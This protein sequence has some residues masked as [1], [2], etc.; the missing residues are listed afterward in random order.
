MW[1]LSYALCD[2]VKDGNTSS[3]HQSSSPFS[4]DK[5]P[6]QDTVQAAELSSRTKPCKGIL[7]RR[8]FDPPEWSMRPVRCVPWNCNQAMRK[9][10]GPHYDECSKHLLRGSYFA[11][12]LLSFVWTFFVLMRFRRRLVLFDMMP[13]KQEKGFF[14]SGT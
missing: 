12:W 11:S 6:S 1:N 5:S 10:G 14:N 2:I 7:G 9:L 8:T 13:D 3:Q 4:S